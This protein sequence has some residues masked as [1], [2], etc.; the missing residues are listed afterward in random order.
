MSGGAG[1]TSGST[2]DAR[3]PRGITIWVDAD[4]A[5]R[6]VKEVVYRAARRLEI[7]AV[8]VANHRLSTPLHNPHVTSVLVR[9]GPD[10]V[11]HHIVERS[12]PGDIAI[13][14]DIPL[15]AALV[16]QG[17]DVLDPRGER[18]TRE[19]VHERLSIRDFMDTLRGSGVDTG[20][21]D[22]FGTADKRA[23]A[24]ALDRLLTAKL[25]G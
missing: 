25:K 14:A 18:Y 1:D 15:A 9:H 6:D 17:L 10:V 11:D 21:P 5:P 22:A 20:G 2:G 16:E 7:P 3:G 8:L 23:F 24:N 4:A 19:N 13:T 12:E